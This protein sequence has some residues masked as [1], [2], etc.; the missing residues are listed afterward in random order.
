MG[1]DVVSDSSGTEP[2]PRS[3]FQRVDDQL[4]KV[5]QA[6]VVGGL[7]VMTFTYVLT[8]L[9]SNMVQPYSQV[10]RALIKLFAGADPESGDPDT[11]AAIADIWSPLVLGLLTFGM[12]LLALRTRARVGLASDDPGP[13][14]NWPRRLLTAALVVV[15]IYGGLWVIE[16][17]PSTALC[18]AALVILVAMACIH[19]Y[20]TKDWTSFVAVVVGG[21]FVAWFFAE[22]AGDAYAW[23]TGLSAVLLMYL[24]FFG[25]SM[26]AHDGRHIRVDAIRKSMKSHRYHLYNAVSDIVAI[27]FTGILFGFALNYLMGEMERGV[28]H[29]LSDLPIWVV[30]LPITVAFGVMVVRFSARV[31][32][33]IASYRRRELPPLPSVEGH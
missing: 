9:W 22:K 18:L 15:A 30:V 24:G 28:M 29:E 3:A 6:I 12:V 13:E 25:A 14:T 21:A 8:V 5:E 26:A 31:G 17:L 2:G 20:R 19:L 7:F 4:Y 16:I 1:E 33:S 11:V 27:A 10:D 32:R 23:N